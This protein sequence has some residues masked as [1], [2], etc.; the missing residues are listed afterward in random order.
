MCSQP[1]PLFLR[2]EPGDEANVLVRSVIYH[3]PSSEEEDESSDMV[4]ASPKTCNKTQNINM[5]LV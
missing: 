1:R 5:T 2:R 4:S 3:V